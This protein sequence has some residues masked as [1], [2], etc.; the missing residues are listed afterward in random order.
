MKDLIYSPNWKVPAA[1][2]KPTERNIIPYCTLH[3]LPSESKQDGKLSN[4]VSIH[5]FCV[6]KSSGFCVS[7]SSGFCVSKSS[8]CSVSKSFGSSVSRSSGFC[9]VN[10]RFLGCCVLLSSEVVLVVSSDEDVYF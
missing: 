2:Y 6:S 4:W 8:R 7:K 3:T 5:V 1:L 10:S 9:F